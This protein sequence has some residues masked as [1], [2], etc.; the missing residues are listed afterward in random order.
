MFRRILL[1]TTKAGISISV[2]NKVFPTFKIP[3]FEVQL[4]TN[5]RAKGDLKLEVKNKQAK[6]CKNFSYCFVKR[7]T[8]RFCDELITGNQVHLY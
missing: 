6:T 4:A 3:V 1:K 5:Y 7:N 8:M 2:F